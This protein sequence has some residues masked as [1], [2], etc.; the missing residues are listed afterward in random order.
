MADEVG[1]FGWREAWD[2]IAERFP[3]CADGS[4]CFGAE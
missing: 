4:Q 1:A 3:E 2:K